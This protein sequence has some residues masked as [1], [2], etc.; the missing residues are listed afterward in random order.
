MTKLPVW[1]TVWEA[2]WAVW[3]HRWRLLRLAA[4]PFVFYVAVAYLGFAVSASLLW[5]DALMG[6]WAYGLVE[7]LSA[8]AMLPLLVE[9]YRLLLLGVD[10]DGAGRLYRFGPESRRLL[11]LLLILHLAWGAPISA[12]HWAIVPGGPFGIARVYAYA[13][14]VF[15]CYALLIY[16]QIRLVFIFPITCLNRPWDLPSRWGETRGNSGRLLAVLVM[17]YAPSVI[18]ILVFHWAHTAPDTAGDVL[19]IPPPPEGWVQWRELRWPGVRSLMDFASL[20]LI[21]SLWFVFPVAATVVA[22]ATLTGYPAKGVRVPRGG[23]EARE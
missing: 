23:G 4:L 9:C 10:R 16:V 14:L 2:Y 21:Y 17:A 19:R 6:M 11:V 5:R 20:G 15:C 12:A 13:G 7:L 22:F 1:T 3:V 8:L 18:V